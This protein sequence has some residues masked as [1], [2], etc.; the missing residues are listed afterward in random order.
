MSETDIQ[1]I[2]RRIS[3]EKTKWHKY[4]DIQD[5]LDAALE[6]IERFE[7]QPCCCMEHEGECSCCERHGALVNHE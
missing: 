7:M 3:E 1:E 2:K 4:A 5:G 6:I